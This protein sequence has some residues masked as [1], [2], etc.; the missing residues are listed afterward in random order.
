MDNTPLADALALRSTA[1]AF[2]AQRGK[3]PVL[4]DRHRSPDTVTL[5][6]QISQLGALITT[7]G[8]QV[9][10]RSNS[11]AQA[12]HTRR[13]ISGFADAVGP[14][15]RAASALGEVA[16]LHSLLDQGEHVRDHP[17]ARGAREVAT[18]AIG[19]SLERADTALRAAADSLHAA[20]S[21]VSPPPGRLRAA[22]SRS[23]TAAPSTAAP[24]APASADA[25]PSNRNG[26]S[27]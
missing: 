20:S 11:E 9:L 14:A 24:P 12:P 4:G 10:F 8:D 26:R 25:V 1:S 23:T 17:D 27:R 5:A 21:T 3:L 16:H 19:H 2:D 18:L 22:R 13:V 7:L 15:A 6:R